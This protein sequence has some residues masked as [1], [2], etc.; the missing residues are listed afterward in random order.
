MTTALT[1]KTPFEAMF[2]KKPEISHLHPFGSTV[3]V[4][5]ES[6]TRSKLDPKAVKCI[7]VGYEDGPH[8]IRYFNVAT[9]QVSIS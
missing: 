3:Y 7:F 6:Q 8:A 2:G 4:L 1:G 9:H 5:N